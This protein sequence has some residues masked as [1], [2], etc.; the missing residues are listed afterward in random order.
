MDGNPYEPPPTPQ[1][2][3]TTR[4]V[5]WPTMMGLFIGVVLATIVGQA[6]ALNG[7]S[8]RAVRVTVLLIFGIA[9]LAGWSVGRRQGNR[10]LT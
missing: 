1:P 6:M 8:E 10:P 7:L 3:A 2:K 4:G 5:H 9:S